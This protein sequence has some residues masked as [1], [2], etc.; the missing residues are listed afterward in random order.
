MTFVQRF[1]LLTVLFFVKIHKGLYLIIKSHSY[2]TEVIGHTRAGFLAGYE[3]EHYAYSTLF[4]HAYLKKQA[5]VKPLLH[6]V[7]TLQSCHLIL[8]T[9]H[10]QSQS[11]H[12]KNMY[13]CPHI[14][15]F[16]IQKNKN[17]I[18]IFIFQV[19]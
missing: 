2:C 15:S 5:S 8:E 6:S 14:L 9:V 11:I 10:K 1:F 19:T 3:M 16:I 7:T 18:F 4:Q 13:I 12:F 17:M